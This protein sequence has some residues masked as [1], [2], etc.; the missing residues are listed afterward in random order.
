[1]LPFV[2]LLVRGALLFALFNCAA[3]ITV[4]YTLDT[5][6]V[7]ALGLT[8]AAVVLS[9]GKAIL[10]IYHGVFDFLQHNFLMPSWTVT[11]LLI[12]YMLPDT[13]QTLAEMYTATVKSF[14]TVLEVCRDQCRDALHQQIENLQQQVATN[15]RLRQ[16]LEDSEARNAVLSSTNDRVAS[17]AFR[18]RKQLNALQDIAAE[19]D[20]KIT[21]MYEHEKWIKEYYNHKAVTSKKR[22]HKIAIAKSQKAVIRLEKEKSELEDKLLGTQRQL[23]G[24]QWIFGEKRKVECEYQAKLNEQ[25]QKIDNQ[26]TKNTRMARVIDYKDIELRKLGLQIA[27]FDVSKKVIFKMAQHDHNIVKISATLYAA[28]L[29]DQG[30]D[31]F[32]LGINPQHHETYYAWAKDMITTGS[33]H[34]APCMG[35]GIGPF[36]AENLGDGLDPNSGSDILPPF[37]S[38]SSHAAPPTPFDTS[39]W[40]LVPATQTSIFRQLDPKSYNRGLDHRDSI[41]WYLDRRLT[42]STGKWRRT[43]VTSSASTTSTGS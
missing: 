21:D 20:D 24:E 30:L 40:W 12:A 41:F 11:M 38:A 5:R 19:K 28:F 31:L 39:L 18:V 23:G 43:V 42:P 35:F 10:T 36:Y 22:E 29:T 13:W 6:Y 25:Q 2:R 3:A 9:F 4:A 26:T 16:L 14:C 37:G 32:E 8:A 34:L 7:D 1:M 33:S 15:C 27:M 17:D